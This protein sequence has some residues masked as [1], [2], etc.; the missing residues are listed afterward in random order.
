M[1]LLARLP[2]GNLP[3]VVPDRGAELRE[4]SAHA[5]L[6]GG[7]VVGPGAA[8][9]PLGEDVFPFFNEALRFLPPLHVTGHCGEVDAAVGRRVLQGVAHLHVTPDDGEPLPHPVV[10]RLDPLA[11]LVDDEPGTGPAG[12]HRGEMRAVALVIAEDHPAGRGQGPGRLPPPGILVH[13]GDGH[14]QAVG[15]ALEGLPR[16]DMAL[17][18]GE[19][20]LGHAARLG[21]LVV[22]LEKACEV[23]FRACGE[24]GVFGKRAHAADQRVVAAHQGQRQVR[25][26]GARDE[27]VPV[28]L[29][30][31]VERPPV[32]FRGFRTRLRRRCGSVLRRR[33]GLRRRR[34]SPRPPSS[35]SSP[36]RIPGASEDRSTARTSTG[37]TARSSVGRTSCRCSPRL[38]R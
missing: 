33:S 2:R 16:L 5:P 18:V 22:I 1:A 27:S 35:T 38:A 20:A 10:R 9:F 23:A 12:R 30:G 13:A 15:P 31:V 32:R 36:C 28:L 21:L 3:V 37:G 14:A 19:P 7:D 25:L 4:R 11:Q 29:H 8:G 34:T 6:A 24:I 26:V 17:R